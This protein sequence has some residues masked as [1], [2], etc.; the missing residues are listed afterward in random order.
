[1]TNVK[2]SDLTVASTINNGDI[3]AIVQGGVSKQ[4]TYANLS[5]GLAPTFA[6]NAETAA[7]TSTTKGVT[8]AGLR[9]SLT[10]GVAQSININGATGVTSTG[11][12]NITGSFKINGVAIGSGMAQ[13]TTTTWT[14]GTTKTITLDLTTYAGYTIHISGV[15]GSSG[16]TIDVDVSTNSG[17]SYVTKN[18]SSSK[19]TGTTTADLSGS[20]GAATDVGASAVGHS[21]FIH[22]SQLST[23]GKMGAAFNGT[24]Q[25][26]AVVN[27][28]G[29]FD[30]TSAVTT[31]KFTISSAPSAGN[32]SFWPTSKR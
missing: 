18:L 1:M 2:F 28:G 22:V 11:D 3:L 17:S 20:I 5:A 8:P 14:S 13:A 9:Y 16:N 10:N 15:A 24:A 6:N 29:T 30:T 7:G 26:S 4:I 19:I 31:L 27:G 25:S 21:I 23:S 12:I 32:I